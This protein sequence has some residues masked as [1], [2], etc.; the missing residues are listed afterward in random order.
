MNRKIIISFS[1][2]IATVSGTGSVHAL[3]FRFS[4]RCQMKWH[5]RSSRKSLG[6]S[7]F[8]FS[9]DFFCIKAKFCLSST[10]EVSLKPFQWYLKF[11][12]HHFK[13]F[14]SSAGKY[15]HGLKPQ[16]TSKL[17]CVITVESLQQEEKNYRTQCIGIIFS[18][19]SIKII[20]SEVVCVYIIHPLS[21]CM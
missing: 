13:P 17:K 12:V 5:Q 4:N 7:F 21:F 3:V 14:S 1:S 18:S 20:F 8:S 16:V 9:F 15:L 19:K 2:E 11:R 10:F 6:K